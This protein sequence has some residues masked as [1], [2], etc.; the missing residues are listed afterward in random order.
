MAY[1]IFWIRLV[2]NCDIPIFRTNVVYCVCYQPPAAVKVETA[3]KCRT[4]PYNDNHGI[5]KNET[6]TNTSKRRLHHLPRVMRKLSSVMCGQQ[7]R[8]SACASAQFDQDLPY[9]LKESWDT[10]ECT[11]GEQGPGR[12]FAH[13]QEVP[14]FRILRMFEVTFWLGAGICKGSLE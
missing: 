9:P 3:L 14:N 2:R 12:Y 8:R 6:K 5:H 10:T 13:A 11:N 7:R 1:S 4:K